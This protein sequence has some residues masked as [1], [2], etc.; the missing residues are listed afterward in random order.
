MDVVLKFILIWIA[1]F[2]L[3][4]SL[5]HLLKLV[6]LFIFIQWSLRIINMLVNLIKSFIYVFLF[7]FYLTYFLSKSYKIWICWMI[8][9]NITISPSHLY[10]MTIGSFNI[11]FKNCVSSQFQ[12]KIILLEM[13]HHCYHSYHFQVSILPLFL[14][15]LNRCWW[16]CHDRLIDFSCLRLWFIISFLW[17]CYCLFLWSNNGCLV[18]LL[19]FWQRFLWYFWYFLI[20]LFYYLLV[21]Y[22]FLLLLC[23]S[24]RFINWRNEILLRNLLSNVFDWNLLLNFRSNWLK[25]VWKEA[26]Q[27][28]MWLLAFWHFKS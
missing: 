25:F 18:L 4:F 12:T 1:Y 6:L 3:F 27:F 19:F 24:F 11:F 20:L 22:F 13:H 23:H 9:T 26:T 28:H 14:F 10:L 21:L 16:F 17:V 15:W 7:L 5:Y 2:L 8:M